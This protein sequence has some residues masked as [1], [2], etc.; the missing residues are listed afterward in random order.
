M[1]MSYTYKYILC[2]LGLRD[3]LSNNMPVYNILFDIMYK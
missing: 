2:G 1:K 3:S